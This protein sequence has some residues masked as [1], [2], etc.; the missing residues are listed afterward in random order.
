MSDELQSFEDEAAEFYRATGYLRP[1][2]SIPCGM[3]TDEYIAERD[4]A[5]KDWTERKENLEAWNKRDQGE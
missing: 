1:G 5:W 4:K 2:K 3:E